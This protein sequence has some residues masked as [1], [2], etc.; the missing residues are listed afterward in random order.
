MIIASRKL[1][2]VDYMGRM[3]YK[4]VVTSFGLGTPDNQVLIDSMAKTESLSD[5][6]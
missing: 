5:C 6:G 3:L 2:F 1:I 4:K